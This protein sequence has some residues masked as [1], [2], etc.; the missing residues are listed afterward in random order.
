MKQQRK[1]VLAVVAAAGITAASAALAWNQAGWDGGCPGYGPGAMQP[2]GQG[3]MMGRHGRGGMMP[4]QRAERMAQRLDMLKYQLKIT[5]A[6]E[7]AW[8][9]FSQSVQSKMAG[10]MGRFQS[11]GAAE[12]Q[13]IGERVQLIRDKATNLQQLADS[14]EQLYAALSPEQRE[15]ADRLPPM[16][17]G[18]MGMRR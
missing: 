17:M 11:G 13:P 14:I 7:P 1:I 3:P 2:Y 6:Q 15:V 16:V 10:M 8:N 12:P 18:M 9:S 4:G 5:E